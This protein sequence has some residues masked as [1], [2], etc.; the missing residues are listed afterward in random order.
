[1]D[2]KRTADGERSRCG[3]LGGGWGCLPACFDVGTVRSQQQHHNPVM[4]LWSSHLFLGAFAPQ[5]QL[6][7]CMT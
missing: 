4:N 7:Y 5:A 3:V 6:M 1:M 2:N